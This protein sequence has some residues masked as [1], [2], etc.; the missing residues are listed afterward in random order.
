MSTTPEQD[1]FVEYLVEQAEDA[2]R[3]LLERAMWIA[4]FAAL[5]SR[6]AGNTK[7]AAEL[8][9]AALGEYRNRFGAT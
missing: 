8:A 5:R 3:R 4:A 1:A 6:S 2:G 7:G 9:D